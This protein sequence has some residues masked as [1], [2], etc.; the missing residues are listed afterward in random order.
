[1]KILLFIA[2]LIIL[3]LI[4][5]LYQFFKEIEDYKKFTEDLNNL[6]ADKN[7]LLRRIE[8]KANDFAG[9][10]WNGS[11]SIGFREIECLSKIRILDTDRKSNI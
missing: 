6:V 3:V 7:R 5:C 9:T 11:P 10:Q 2:V 4:Y 8:S 1:M